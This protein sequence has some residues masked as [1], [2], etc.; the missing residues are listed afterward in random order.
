M[1]LD[2]HPAVD[3][4]LGAGEESAVALTSVLSS[5]DDIARR[6]ATGDRHRGQRPAA[7]GMTT[8]IWNTLY[9]GSWRTVFF[10]DT[11]TFPQYGE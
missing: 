6:P 8:V 9:D 11:P 2:G 3:T 4:Q 1:R 5:P 10:P 7:S